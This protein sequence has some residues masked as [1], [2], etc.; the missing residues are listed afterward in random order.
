[1]SFGLKLVGLVQS[2]DNYSSRFLAKMIRYPQPTSLPFFSP[3][4]SAIP[5]TRADRGTYPHSLRGY[6]TAGQLSLASLRGRLIDYQLRLGVRAG[7][8]PLPGDR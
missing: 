6:A 7:M 2:L 8:S 3:R 1:V 5:M 4:I